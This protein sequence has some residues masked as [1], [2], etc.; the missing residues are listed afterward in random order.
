MTTRAA[1]AR[2]TWEAPA[3]SA[4][5]T[6]CSAAGSPSC[7][8]TTSP[9]LEQ[10]YDPDFPG[11]DPDRSLWIGETGIRLVLHRLAPS[12]G[13]ADRLAALIHA[14]RSDERC[15]LMWGSPGTMLAANAMHELTGDPGAALDLAD[16]LAGAGAVPAA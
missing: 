9:Y 1:S 13:N 11:E 8:A 5:S 7:G 15:E 2:S 10:P 12:T 16:C 3:S 4:R 6:T 14:N